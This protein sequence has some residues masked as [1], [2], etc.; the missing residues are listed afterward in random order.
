AVPAG[1]RCQRRHSAE[2]PVAAMTDQDMMLDE[3]PAPP[4]RR[5][6]RRWLAGAAVAVIV[7]GAAAA[8]TITNPFGTAHPAQQTDNSAATSL[9]TVAR[10]TITA[11]TQVSG[12][13]GYAGSYSIINQASGTYTRLP[14]T[15][16]VIRQ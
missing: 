16:S 8:A 11:Q 10:R 1:R 15:G 5:H 9:A 4:S 14:G 3:Q 2:G 12:T 6:P 7:A 13:L